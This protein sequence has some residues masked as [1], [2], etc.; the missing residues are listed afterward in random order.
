VR[1][2]SVSAGSQFVSSPTIEA[3]DSG[4]CPPWTYRD[5]HHQPLVNLELTDL[6]R[7]YR[8]DLLIEVEMALAPTCANGPPPPLTSG[9]PRINSMSPIV[10]GVPL[11]TEVHPC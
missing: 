3:G 8:V 2:V 10:A 1:N 11:L 9:Y 4:N 6:R 7:L 5:N